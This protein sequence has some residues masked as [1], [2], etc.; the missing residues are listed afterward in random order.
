MPLK[1][2]NSQ[3]FIHEMHSSNNFGQIFEGIFAV[4]ESGT[5]TVVNAGRYLKEETAGTYTIVA[6]ID[7]QSRVGTILAMGYSSIA[8]GCWMAQRLRAVAILEQ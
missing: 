1:A 3:E 5:L 4:N 2:T 7:P 8:R 6:R